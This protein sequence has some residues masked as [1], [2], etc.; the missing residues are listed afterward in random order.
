MLVGLGNPG[1]KYERTRHNVGFRVA[2]EAARRLG[3]DLDQTK[4]GALCGVAKKDRIALVLPQTYMNVSGESVGAAARFWKVDPASIVVAHDEIDLE[5]DRIQ[6]KVGG[7][8]AGHNGLKSL[9][10]H[11]GTTDF[12]RVRIGVGRPPAGWE[13]ADWVLAKFTP[14]E[15][16]TLRDVIGEG[17]Q[18]AIDALVEGPAAAMNRWNKKKSTV[19]SRQSTGKTE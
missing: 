3:A 1:P 11:L 13:G 5:F 6:V 15:E 17:A 18:A 4:F 14:A 16:H 2:E 10:Q 9:Q 8:V 19:D 12:V 7:G